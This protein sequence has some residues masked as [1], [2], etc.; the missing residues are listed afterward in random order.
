MKKTNK[1]ILKKH[2]KNTKNTKNT[3]KIKYNFHKKKYI[4]GPFLMYH[5]PKLPQDRKLLI[6]GEIHHTPNPCDENKKGMSITKYL[7]K[8]SNDSKE[9]IDIYIEEFYKTTE[10]TKNNISKKK[11][12]MMNKMNQINNINQLREEFRNCDDRN[13][14]FC[15]YKN[16]RIHFSDPRIIYTTNKIDDSGSIDNLSKNIMNGSILMTPEIHLMNTNLTSSC[17]QLNTNYPK[18]KEVIKF[19]M[20]WKRSEK[21]KQYYCDYIK[22]ITSGHSYDGLINNWSEK[23]FQIIDKEIGKIKHFSVN[24]IYKTLY[25]IYEMQYENVNNS[26]FNITLCI[27]MDMYF[28]F[29][30]LMNFKESNMDRG[31]TGCIKTNYSKNTIVYCGSFHA[32]TYKNFIDS[33]FNTQPEIAIEQVNVNEINSMKQLN[34]NEIN[35]CLEL[36]DGFNF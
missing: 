12:N 15:K 23:Y 36:P 21:Y 28:I 2:N 26:T 30:Y 11:F 27:P 17:Y 8:I 33:F 6:F 4:N 9:C 19:L 5:Y 25:K 29:R 16:A 7:K 18:F 32:T 3:K 31:P 13:K 14:S 24:K 35:S 34:V 10:F 22:T 20:G 1:L